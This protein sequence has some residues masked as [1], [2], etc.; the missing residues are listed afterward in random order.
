MGGGEEKA[1]VIK[2]IGNRIYH[3]ITRL[4][5]TYVPTK[6]CYVSP[7]IIPVYEK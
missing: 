3:D 7:S 1:V 2:R 5:L 6:A 4:S